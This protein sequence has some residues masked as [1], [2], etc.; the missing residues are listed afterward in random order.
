MLTL[1]M[2]GG[3]EF[4]FSWVPDALPTFLQATFLTLQILVGSLVLSIAVGLVAG[5]LLMSKR[6]WIR[7]PARVYVDFFR[8][9]PMLLQI[10]AIFFLLPLAFSIQVPPMVSGILA[11]G[12]N[13]G[14]FF[15]EIFRAGVMSLDRGQWEGSESLGMSHLQTLRRVIYP[16]AIRRML[17]PV[18]SMIVGLT[19]DTSLLSVIGVAEVFNTAQTVGSRTFRQLE[20]LL[21]ISLIYLIINLPLAISAERVHQRVH[22]NA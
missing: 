21:F 16:Q 5:Q 13:Y 14:A 17:P 6:W 22:V 10:V 1:W 2:S 12:L 19:K 11:L 15:S 9:T 18:G 20:V 7:M 8:L 4:D 3:Y